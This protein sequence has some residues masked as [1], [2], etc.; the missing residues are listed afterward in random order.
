MFCYSAVDELLQWASWCSL[1]CV[2]CYIPGGGRQ[3]SEAVVD[4]V[5][6]MAA[7]VVDAERQTGRLTSS[8][9]A[10]IAW[11]AAVSAAVAVVTVLTLY[12][13]RRRTR[14]RSSPG[15]ATSPCTPS[16]S[17]SSTIDT[18]ER[19]G[20]GSRRGT[21]GLRVT[22]SLPSSQVVEVMSSAEVLNST[23]TSPVICDDDDDRS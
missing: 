1:W 7:S 21:P 8:Y 15:G 12:R 13:R 10:L 23:D 19:C 18:V 22:S 3:R 16:L 17:T 9:Y 11:V 20:S 14:R 4:N 6:D 5:D 2:V